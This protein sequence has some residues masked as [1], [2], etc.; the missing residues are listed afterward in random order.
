[1]NHQSSHPHLPGVAGNSSSRLPEGT[2]RVREALSGAGTLVIIGA[3]VFLTIQALGPSAAP[4]TAPP[5]DLSIKTDLASLMENDDRF[6]QDHVRLDVSK[7]VVR[8]TGTVL[9]P[10]EKGLAEEHATEIPGVRGIQDEIWVLPS[11]NEDQDLQK[12]VESTLIDNSL[13]DIRGM[14]VE[15][16]DGVVTLDGT[17]SRPVLKRLADRLVKSTPGVSKIIDNTYV[18]NENKGNSRMA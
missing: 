12:E 16:H 11:I 8:L 14:Q 17:V 7:G 6:G 15:A 4:D 2:H 9:T 10:E 5:G 3:A 1:M 13:V 18:Y